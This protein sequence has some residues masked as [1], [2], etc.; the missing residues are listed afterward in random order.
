MLPYLFNLFTATRPFARVIRGIMSCL[1]TE[2]R[3]GLEAYTEEDEE[4]LAA[5]RHGR[6]NERVDPQARQ[7][8]PGTR[9]RADEQAGGRGGED[10]SNGEV[11][12]AIRRAEVHR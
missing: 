1:L 10:Q 11:G 5:D 8:E 2:I 3:A 4:A 7:Q 6:H 9:Y 12:R